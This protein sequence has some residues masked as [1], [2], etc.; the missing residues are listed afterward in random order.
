VAGRRL[1]PAA[2][3]WLLGACLLG[4]VAAAEPEAPASPWRRLEPGLE[5]AAFPAPQPA[6]LGDSTIRVLRIDPERFALR[7]LNA[8]AS[9]AGTLRTARGWAQE[10]EL[11]A[12]INASMYQTDYLSSVS[13]MINRAHV[14][15]PRVSKDNAVLAFDRK[16]AE[17][18]RIQIIDRKCQDFDGLRNHY[19]VLVQSIRMISCHGGNVWGQQEQKWSIAAI[20][21]DAAGRVLFIHCRSPYS[22]H[23]LIDMLL[24]LPIGLR[25][26]MYVEGGPEAQLYVRAGG[27]ELE[28]YGSLETGLFDA[29]ANGR[30]WPIP[31]AIGVVRRAAHGADAPDDSELDTPTP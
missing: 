5:L 27:E 31:N 15:N 29:D 11:V 23:D 3:A 28:F 26:A 20:G 19:R 10:H 12:A 30:A 9:D 6:Q 13:L 4:G 7:L 18:P 1:R 21:I 17:V 25:N 14:N 8:S 22:V 2:C 24:G 16:D